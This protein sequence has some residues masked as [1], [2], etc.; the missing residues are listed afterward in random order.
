MNRPQQEQPEE[1]PGD[2]TCPICLG[3]M[4][5]PACINPCRHSFCLECIHVWA[6]ERVSCPMCRGLIIAIVRLVPPAQRDASSRRPR[7]RLE[8]NVGLGRRQQRQRSPSSY[9]S[10]S[11]SP[12]RRERSPPMARQLAR[13]FS[14]HSGHSG[15]GLPRS[16]ED[17][18]LGDLLWLRRVQLEEPGSGDHA[19]RQARPQD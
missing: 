3:R 1:A 14:W 15:R 17:D 13:S 16:P 4:S 7:R 11:V 6:A 19:G 8:R 18:N 9:R 2:E 12:R 5:S 10:R